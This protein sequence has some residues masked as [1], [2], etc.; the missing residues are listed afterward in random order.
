MAEFIHQ[1][2]ITRRGVGVANAEVIFGPF[3]VFT[4][5]QDGEAEIE[6]MMWT[7]GDKIIM[8]VCIMDPSDGLAVIMSRIIDNN[9]SCNIEMTVHG[10]YR[11]PDGWTPP[12]P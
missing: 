11:D 4:A 6:V 7:W 8:P 10:R 9:G 12:A 5:D 2:T 3:G 1:M